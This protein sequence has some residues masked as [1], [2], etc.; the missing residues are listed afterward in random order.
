MKLKRYQ[1][2][3]LDVLR[4]YLRRAG[5]LND[6]DTA[7]YEMTRRA[8]RPAPGFE[9][10]PYVCLRVPTGGGKTLIASHAVP[11]AVRELLH[12]DRGIVLWLAPTTKIVEQTLKRLR[13]VRDP[14]RR[15]LESG[16]P[17]SVLT[18]AEALYLSRPA[19]DGETV[20]IVM[21]IQALRV[22]DTEGRKIYAD[23]GT[24]MPHFEDRR[25][26]DAARD[27]LAWMPEADRP[28]YSLANVL[29]LRRGTVVVDEAHNARTPLSFE[30]FERFRPAGIL[31]LTAT[32]NEDARIGSN[33]LH[34]VSAAELK[35]EQMVKLPVMLATRADW[36][37]LLNEAVEKRAELETLWRAETAATGDALR[38]IL[39]VQAESKGAGDRKT[40]EVVKQFLINDLGQPVGSVRIVTGGVDELGEDRAGDPAC[41]V[42]AVVTVQ[43]LREGWDCPAAYVLASVANLS[44]ET[45]AEQMLGRV[46]RM[47]FA[48]YRSEAALNRAYAYVT[49]SFVDAAGR[50]TEGLVS[51]GMPRYE[52]AREVRANAPLLPNLGPLFGGTV[53][54]DWPADQPPPPLDALPPALRDRFTYEP[55][56]RRLT[57]SGPVLS[58][59]EAEQV[60]AVAGA[61]GEA[62]RLAAERI[63]RHRAGL[64]AAPADLGVTLAVPRLA[65]ASDRGPVLFETQYRDAPWPLPERDAALDESDFSLAAP[66]GTGAKIDIDV[67]GDTTLETLDAVWGQ[68]QLF[69][70]YAPQTPAALAAWLARH[71]PHVDLI[72]S[73]VRLWLLAAVR[74]LTTERELPLQAVTA[75]RFRLRDA[76]EARVD[77]LRRAAHA[78]EY[79]RLLYADGGPPPRTTP[80]VAFT[81]PLNAY[82]A[83][84]PYQGSFRPNRHYYATV[85][86]M[87]G[88]EADVAMALDAHP[89]VETWVRNLEREGWGFWIPTADGR[90]FPD[91]V[92]RLT[93]GR[94][95]AVEHKGDHLADSRRQLRKRDAGNLWSDCSGGSCLFV[96]TEGRNPHRQATEA[97]A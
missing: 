26:V 19:V 58:R 74:H 9:R 42:R 62:G 51:C 28:V 44:S 7:F 75:A 61:A 45:A 68:L 70:R 8:Y 38:P 12:A 93:D 52:A 48:R 79:Q 21:P 82:P 64:D 43:K 66:G 80:A 39:L 29:A 15:A 95:A 83:N 46:L 22:D 49:G 85:A 63:V 35:A 32:P 57:Y 54:A 50:I 89:L 34:G 30:A 84:R 11:L 60:R 10:L 47:P 1:Q 31:E 55:Q 23:N 65:I 40:P 20:V 67:N 41:E 72:P 73:Q 76:V 6:G 14:Y 17:A 91:F 90:F 25:V 94:H 33:V 27:R 3:C 97:I 87:N 77:A 88:E 81:F 59:G 78:A 53:E 16:G 92:A 18:L 86:D 56:D 71:V 37:T 36:Q 13:D 4:D 69:D 96:W 2:E 5:K 24:L